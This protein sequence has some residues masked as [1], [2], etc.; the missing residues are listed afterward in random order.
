MGA[1]GM[2]FKN[3]SPHFPWRYDL[4]IPGRFLVSPPEPSLERNAALA[5]IMNKVWRLRVFTEEFAEIIRSFYTA[6]YQG[7]IQAQF[8]DCE[9][10]EAMVRSTPGNWFILARGGY[11]DFHS[12]AAIPCAARCA[13]Y[14]L[15]GSFRGSKP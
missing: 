13:Y 8:S 3:V 5:L 2:I 4:L 11:M 1:H 7:Q 15:D 12:S 14:Q 6:S 9:S 10:F